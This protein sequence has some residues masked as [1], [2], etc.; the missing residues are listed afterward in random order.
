MNTTSRK[1]LLDLANESSIIRSQIQYKFDIIR[2][3]TNA[4]DKMETVG[5]NVPSLSVA[6]TSLSASPFN[7]LV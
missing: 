6:R 5:A 4:F 2:Q 7:G 1:I 3:S